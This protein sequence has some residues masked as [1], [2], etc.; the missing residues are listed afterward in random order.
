[1]AGLYSLWRIS[2]IIEEFGMGVCP[3]WQDNPIQRILFFFDFSPLAVMAWLTA[4][5]LVTWDVFTVGLSL[6]VY[7][8]WGMN[9]LFNFALVRQEGPQGPYCIYTQ[10]QN[11]AYN[12]EQVAVIFMM[13]LCLGAVYRT[14]RVPWYTMVLVALNAGL[15]IVN[16]IYRRVNTVEAVITGGLLGMVNGYIGFAV[17]YY[18]APY[19]T[20]C[21][22]YMRVG[23]WIGLRNYYFR[24]R[25][26][27][28]EQLLVHRA[29][30]RIF[31]N[32]REHD[33]LDTDWARLS[34]GIWALQLA[35]ECQRS[36]ESK[37]SRLAL[38]ADDI[39]Y[40]LTLTHE[41]ELFCE[42]MQRGLEEEGG[43]APAYLRQAI[44]QT[45][46]DCMQVANRLQLIPSTSNV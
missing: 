26:E 22:E 35:A 2:E 7:F 16:H 42:M 41:E 25:G 3:H 27:T 12:V 32:F 14:W 31:A 11:P 24:K 4:M 37:N 19:C 1:M 15:L 10:Y 30:H 45:M 33:R 46:Q 20:N 28:P 39:R 9:L 5:S 40:S 6:V 36:R 43:S 8:D 29:E 21:L 18:L 23:R 34:L 38:L 17:L 44:D 13:Y